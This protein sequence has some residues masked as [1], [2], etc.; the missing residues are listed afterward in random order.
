MR[1]IDTVKY[2]GIPY[3]HGGDD[4]DVGVNCYGLAKLFTDKNLI[5]KLYDLQI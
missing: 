4:K 1:I 2:L 3:K 5:L